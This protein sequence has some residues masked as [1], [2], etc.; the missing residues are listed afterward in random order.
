[1]AQEWAVSAQDVV[2]RRTKLGLRLDAAQVAEI[3]AY[4]GSSRT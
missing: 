2:W 4:M 3:E 1:M